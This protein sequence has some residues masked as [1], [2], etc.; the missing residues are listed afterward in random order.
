MIIPKSIQNEMLEKI[1]KTHLGIAAS[2]RKASGIM[3]W[4]NV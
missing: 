2:L 4:P 1:H 3:H